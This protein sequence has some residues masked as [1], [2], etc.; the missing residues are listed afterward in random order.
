MQILKLSGPFSTVCL[1]ICM[2]WGI[3][4]KAIMDLALVVEKEILCKSV[5]ASSDVWFGM[6]Q[7]SPFLAHNLSSIA[8]SHGEGRAG[9]GC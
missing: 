1:F 4:R 3:F 7:N 8:Q 5:Y 9:L 6:F 2:T